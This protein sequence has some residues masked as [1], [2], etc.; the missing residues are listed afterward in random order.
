MKPAPTGTSIRQGGYASGDA[1]TLTLSWGER[2][3]RQ[4]Q[5]MARHLAPGPGMDGFGCGAG[6]I[7][8]DSRVDWQFAPPAGAGACP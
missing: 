1:L 8:M 6:R 7:Q 4:A 2:A 5:G 3:I